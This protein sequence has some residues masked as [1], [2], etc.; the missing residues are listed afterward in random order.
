MEIGLFWT[1]VLLAGMVTLA[2]WLIK[3]LFPASAA[4]CRSSRPSC[5]S[6]G[7][8]DLHSPAARRDQD[9]IEKPIPG[10]NPSA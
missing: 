2:V 5:D 7:L 1:F 9:E 10:S 6:L 4:P 3:L 8:V